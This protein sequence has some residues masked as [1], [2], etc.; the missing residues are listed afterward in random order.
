MNTSKMKIIC[1]FCQ[2]VRF[3]GEPTNSCHNGMVLLSPLSPYS[4]KL[5]SHYLQC[6]HLAI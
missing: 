5:N 6:F 1:Q 3:P 2:A 4:V